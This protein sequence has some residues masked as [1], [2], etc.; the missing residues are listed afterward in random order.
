MTLTTLLLLSSIIDYLCIFVQFIDNT[1]MNV[2]ATNK[3]FIV[4]IAVPFQK[5]L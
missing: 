4:L 3:Y 1:K 5:L 2:I